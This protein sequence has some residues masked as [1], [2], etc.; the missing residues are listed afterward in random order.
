MK[1]GLNIGGNGTKKWYLNGIR[2]REDGPAVE[3]VNG[4]KDW[5][6]NGKELSEDDLE[7]QMIK[8]KYERNQNEGRA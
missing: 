1:D 3:W 8:A 5:Y 6:L 7:Y 4:D 2:H